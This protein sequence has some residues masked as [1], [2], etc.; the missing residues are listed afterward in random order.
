MG[1]FFVAALP[2]VVA[3]LAACGDGGAA[4]TSGDRP[5][6]VAASISVFADMARQVGGE[7]VAVIALIPPGADAHTFQPSPKDVKRLGDV[8]AVFLNGAHLEESLQGIIAGATPKQARVV[9]LSEGLRALDFEPEPVGPEPRTAKEG[10]KEEGEAGG[11]P[12]FWLDIANARQYVRRIRDT[13]IEVDGEGRAAYTANAERYLKELDDTDAYIRAQIETIP[14]EQRRLV[15]FHDA[16][17]YFAR[18]YGLEP[19]GYVVRAPGREP[20]ARE[21]KELGEIIRRQR[22]RAVFKEP[23][24]NA[25]LL[26]RAARDAG[27]R[28]EILYSDA[29]TRDVPSYIAMMR[30]NA[31]TIAR[32]L[33]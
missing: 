12:H 28:V 22:V 11:N 21:I 30:R 1:R 25:R 24:V 7:R 16:F 15:T 13:L 19:A 10:G 31:D 4:T 14:M 17:P 23:Q 20:S 5:V 29:L 6:R 26:D 2:V 33:R 27:V 8:R 3:F 18:A 9:E 32:S